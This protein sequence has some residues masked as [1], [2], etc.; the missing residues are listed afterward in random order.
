M[1]AGTVLTLVG[2]P[3]VTDFPNCTLQP[4]MRPGLLASLCPSGTDHSVD[5]S[6]VLLIAGRSIQRPSRAGGEGSASK[7]MT[8]IRRLT[9]CW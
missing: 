5:G 3:A 4:K 7:I 9:R 6:F 1:F 2:I 8:G